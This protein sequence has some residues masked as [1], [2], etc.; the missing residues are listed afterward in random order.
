V[1]EGSIP[2]DW[3]SSLLVQISKV[4]GLKFIQRDQIARTCYEGDR[5]SF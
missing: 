4:R 3:K 5:K 2:E 1:K